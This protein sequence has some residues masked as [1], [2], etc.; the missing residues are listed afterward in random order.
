MRVEV[1]SRLLPASG[2]PNRTPR[3]GDGQD[4]QDRDAS[5]AAA[6]RRRSTSWLQRSQQ[7]LGS[8]WPPIATCG[9]RRLPSGSRSRSM[10]R[11]R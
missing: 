9:R 7:P 2:N 6:T 11:P 4:Q 10:C 5:S 3:N 1:P 8:T